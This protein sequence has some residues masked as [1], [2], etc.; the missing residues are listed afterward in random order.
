V[1]ASPMRLG[2]LWFA[3]QLVWGAILA[4]S[5]QERSSALASDDGVRA[6]ASIAA[7][8]GAVA[9][10]VQLATGFLA[11]RAVARTGSRSIFYA[12]GVVATV[13]ALVWFYLAPTYPQLMAAFFLI[14]FALNVATGPYQAA[15]PDHVEPERAGLASAWMSAYQFVGN[16]TG[17]VVAG[18]VSDARIVA[19][20]LGGALLATFSVTFAHVRRLRVRTMRAARL[21]VT[22]NFVELLVSRSLVNVGFYTLLGFLLFFVRDALGAVDVRTSTALL[23]LT[24]TI[25]GVGGATLAARPVDRGDPRI[26]AGAAI[27]IIVVALGALASATSLPFAFVAAAFAGIAWGAFATADWALACRLLPANAMAAAMGVWNLATTLPQVVAPLLAGAVVARI[28]VYDRALGPRVAIVL[29]LAEMAAGA[30][31]LARVK[32]FS[33]RAEPLAD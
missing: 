12:A 28:D 13:P 20:L 7:L 16:A 4:V 14:Q 9:A 5:L 8:G 21:V 15:I 22:R 33:A 10:A 2:A 30:A 29:A 25:A 17:L 23:F 1:I 27:G 31:W 19:A 18:F 26:V 32:L 3:I 6:Y 24:F 11:D